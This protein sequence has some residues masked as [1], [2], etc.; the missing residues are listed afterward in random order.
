M[1]HTQKIVKF[2]GIESIDHPS[3]TEHA[4]W[5][6]CSIGIQ[7]DLLAAAPLQK[8]TTVEEIFVT[9]NEDDINAGK[10]DVGAREADLDTSFQLSQEDT[11]TE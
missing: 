5:T 11:T 4:G 9:D 8:L 2:V 7:C 6:T 3:T 1:Q 10:A